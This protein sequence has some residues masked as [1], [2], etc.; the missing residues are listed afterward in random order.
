M[1]TLKKIFPYSFGTKDVKALVIKILVYL[2]A[3]A[4]IG[5][6]LGLLAGIP[7][8]GVIIGIVNWLIGVYALIGII[9][10]I[11]DFVKK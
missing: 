1:D 5:W 9:L 6:V 10:V 7:V 4:V 2:V 8:I 3:S 11:V